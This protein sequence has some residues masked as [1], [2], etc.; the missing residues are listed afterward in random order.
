MKNAGK[1][2]SCDLQEKKLVRIADGAARLGL[3]SIE[4]RAMDAS[5][6][7]ETLFEKADTV[8]ADVPCSGFGVIRKK[9]EIRYKREED[10]AGLPEIQLKILA[11]LSR[12]VKHGGVLLYSTCTLLPRENEDVIAVFLKEH[13]DFAPEPFELPVPGGDAAAGFTTLWPHRTGTDG[14]FICRLRRR[15]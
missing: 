7:D 8:I 3:T 10:I 1:I 6:P 2:L 12:Y 13:T 11:N 15:V 9:P 5:V 14:F 4:A